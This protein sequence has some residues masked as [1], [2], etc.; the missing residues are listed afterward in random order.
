ML[1]ELEAFKAEHGIAHVG[2]P[3]MHDFDVLEAS[4]LLRS[5]IDQ[6]SGANC[7]V[8]VMDKFKSDISSKLEGV[9]RV[10]LFS[11]RSCFFFI[12]ASLFQTPYQ[13][14]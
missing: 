4:A 1:L 13:I 14:R 10:L 11:S 9:R 2:L 6:I 3:L 12:P 5:L 8:M 7:R